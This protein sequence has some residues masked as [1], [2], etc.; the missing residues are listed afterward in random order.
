MLHLYLYGDRSIAT[1][2]IDNFDVGGV[3]AGSGIFMPCIADSFETASFA[4]AVVLPVVSEGFT[5][6]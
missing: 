2:G 6:Y 5:D 4:G 1:E 3:F